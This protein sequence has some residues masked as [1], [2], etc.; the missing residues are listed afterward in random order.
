MGIIMNK[1][2][3]VSDGIVYYY[4]NPAGIIKENQVIIDAIFNK[5]DLI[6]FVAAEISQNIV[7]TEGVYKAI[8]EAK[9]LPQI[10]E[11]IG[12]HMIRIYQLSLKSPVDVRFVTLKDR[13][14]LGYGAPRKEEYDL[15]YEE[16]IEKFDLEEIW[17]RFS[18]LVPKDF[19]HHSMSISDVVEH[20]Q[21]KKSSFY[22]LDR[23]GF[24][25]ISFNDTAS[26]GQI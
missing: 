21:G 8:Y 5:E 18:K 7:I 12:Q 22:Y 1:T 26:A 13:E 15:A 14:N 24:V 25:E 3:Y 9:E 16:V 6:Q 10:A 11:E 23:N 20:V 19:K 4:E 2:I 17:D